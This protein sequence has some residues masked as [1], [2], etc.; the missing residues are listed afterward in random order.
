MVGIK[1]LNISSFC[2]FQQ[3]LVKAFRGNNRNWLDWSVKS[4]QKTLAQN[5][6]DT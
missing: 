6:S 1:Y 3:T 2:V 5:L 4:L